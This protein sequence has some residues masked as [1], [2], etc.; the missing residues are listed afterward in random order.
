MFITQI[1]CCFIYEQPTAELAMSGHDVVLL[2]SL[3]SSLQ[4]SE[5]QLIPH[6]LK[7]LLSLISKMQLKHLNKKNALEVNYWNNYC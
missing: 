7:C 2:S 6:I 3:E 4:S 5:Y 1:Y